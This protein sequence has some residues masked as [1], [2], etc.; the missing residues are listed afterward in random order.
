[1][2]EQYVRWVGAILL[3]GDLGSSLWQNTP[4]AELLLARLPVTFELG[5]DGAD[6]R[7]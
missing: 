6:R 2:W 7:R 3:H 5:A 4:V 1:M